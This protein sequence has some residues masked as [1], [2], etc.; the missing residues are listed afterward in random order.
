MA[1]VAT[2]SPGPSAVHEK[3]ADADLHR[4][5]PLPRFE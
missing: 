4:R 5:Q 1:T 2:V 3:F